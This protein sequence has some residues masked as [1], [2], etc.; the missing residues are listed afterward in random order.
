M[1]KNLFSCL[2]H[3]LN[4]TTC[5][6]PHQ[7]W[8]QTHITVVLDMHPSGLLLRCFLLAS[9]LGRERDQT[10]GL[11]E[12][13]TQDKLLLGFTIITMINVVCLWHV[14]L[15]LQV[16]ERLQ[17]RV[18]RPLMSWNKK[19]RQLSLKVDSRKMQSKPTGGCQCL[20]PPHKGM[21]PVLAES[22]TVSALISWFQFELFC[23]LVFL[24]VTISIMTT[25]IL[26]EN[27]YYPLCNSL[28]APE[29]I[30]QFTSVTVALEN[31][32]L[33]PSTQTDGF[34]TAKMSSKSAHRTS[35]GSAGHRLSQHIRQDNA[36]HTTGGREKSFFSQNTLTSELETTSV[37]V[38]DS[39]A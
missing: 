3:R 15:L 12:G 33:H 30:L 32:S 18:I 22:F 37:S 7:T 9:P 1:G 6:P 4:R 24:R 2:N 36:P 25:K 14:M 21:F 27:V 26:E 35:K 8:L 23:N 16:H 38:V 10:N 11:G 19:G 20:G 28:C 34:K 5:P 31:C 13:S 29:G 17:A 39:E